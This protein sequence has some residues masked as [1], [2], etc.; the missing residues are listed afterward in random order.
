MHTLTTL[1]FKSIFFRD[2][3]NSAKYYGICLFVKLGS[4]YKIKSGQFMV[5]FW[6]HFGFILGSFWGHFCSPFLFS[7][8]CELLNINPDFDYLRF[9]I[10]LIFLSKIF[11]PIFSRA[12]IFCDGVVEMLDKRLYHIRLV[13]LGGHLV[14]VIV[15]LLSICKKRQSILCHN[16]IY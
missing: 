2:D 1:K 12:Y 3:R 15:M 11:L 8:S 6:V 13:N 9:K 5:S 14:L 4:F 7:N 10:Y 16:R